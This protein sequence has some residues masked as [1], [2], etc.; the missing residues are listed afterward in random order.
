MKLRKIVSSM[1]QL[2]DLCFLAS[3]A[4]FFSLYSM[5]LLPLSIHNSTVVCEIPILGLEFQNSVQIVKAV[6]LLFFALEN[7]LK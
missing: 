3:G 4:I 6:I 1:L 5:L 2:C 7:S